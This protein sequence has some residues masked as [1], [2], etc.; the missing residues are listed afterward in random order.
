MRCDGV[1]DDVLWRH[2]PTTDG[3]TTCFFPAQALEAPHAVPRR[4]TRDG[5]PLLPAY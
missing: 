5:C 4:E 3:F 2:E 1:F